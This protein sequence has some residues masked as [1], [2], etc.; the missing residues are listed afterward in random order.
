[1]EIGTTAA[2]LEAND[3]SNVKNIVLIH[4]SSGNSNG[5]EFKNRIQRETGI[6][7]YIAALG[8][9]LQLNNF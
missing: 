1:M 9:K 4:L 8:M 3:L 5:P 6:P 7:T 2:M